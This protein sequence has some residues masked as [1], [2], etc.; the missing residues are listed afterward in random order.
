[1]AED[2]PR[3]FMVRAEIAGIY[4][5][6]EF[7]FRERAVF[8]AFIAARP[9]GLTFT[10]IHERGTYVTLEE[11]L[12]SAAELVAEGLAEQGEGIAQG[13]PR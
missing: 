11:A 13:Q 9:E 2:E 7:W 3:I 4:P 1:M 8:D 6:Q 5:A 10:D 12:E